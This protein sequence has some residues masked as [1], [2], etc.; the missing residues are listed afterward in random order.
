MRLLLA[1]AF[2]LVTWRWGD[3][4]NWRNYHATILFYSLGSLLYEVLTYKYPMW[5]YAGDG[6]L[7]NHTISA[8]LL[9]FVAFPCTVLLFLPYTRTRG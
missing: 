5:Q 8:L 6:I 7:P 2:V 4:R 3:W 9:S 1:V